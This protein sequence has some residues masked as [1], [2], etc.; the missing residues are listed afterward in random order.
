MARGREADGPL[1][2]LFTYLQKYIT[3]EEVSHACKL[4]NVLLV[5]GFKGFSCHCTGHSE[6]LFQQLLV[7]YI[8]KTLEN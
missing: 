2:D 7:V 5:Q 8:Y 4:Q 6:I 1:A 3:F